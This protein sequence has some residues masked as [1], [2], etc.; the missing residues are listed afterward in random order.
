MCVCHMNKRLLTYLLT[1]LLTI[2]CNCGKLPQ[3]YKT[4]FAG[5][6]HYV[7]LT[8]CIIL[9]TRR[10]SRCFTVFQSVGAYFFVLTITAIRRLKNAVGG[11]FDFTPKISIRYSA[12]FMFCI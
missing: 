6:Q 10:L 3:G 7:L 12:D 4:H 2:T 8:E 11:K 1:Y 9:N 5:H